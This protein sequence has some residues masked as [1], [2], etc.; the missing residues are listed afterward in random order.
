M[1]WT[2]EFLRL[3]ASDPHQYAEQ[4]AEICYHMA[5]AIEGSM[6]RNSMQA[7]LEKSK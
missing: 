4:M 7:V 1:M 5:E 2:P 6:G 3:M